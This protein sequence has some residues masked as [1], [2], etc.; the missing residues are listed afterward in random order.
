MEGSVEMKVVWGE[1]ER[2][3]CSSTYKGGGTDGRVKG[4]EWEGGGESG[5]AEERVGGRE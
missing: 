4:R 3:W 5:R 2:T 1:K